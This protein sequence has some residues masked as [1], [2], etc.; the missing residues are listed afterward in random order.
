MVGFY[1]MAVLV[2]VVAVFLELGGGRAVELAVKC[3]DFDSSKIDLKSTFH[4]EELKQVGHMEGVPVVEV[5]EGEVA[6]AT[7][8][9]DSSPDY[10]SHRLKLYYNSIAAASTIIISIAA[11]HSSAKPPLKPF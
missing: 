1:I 6:T 3:V 2:D 7:Q 10:T 4:L 8:T 5:E 11:A 9:A